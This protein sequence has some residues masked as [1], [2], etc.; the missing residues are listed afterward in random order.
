MTLQGSIT[1]QWQDIGFQ[2]DDPTTDFRGMGLLGL[3][4]LQYFAENHNSAARHVLSRSHH[5]VYGYSF[6]I[7]GIN[8]T[9]LAY[10]LLEDGSLKHHFYNVSVSNPRVDA[11]PGDPS[12]LS[13]PDLRHFHQLYC[14]LF[15][16]FDALWRNE[17]PKDIMEFSRIRDKFEHLLRQRLKSYDV[18]LKTDFVLENV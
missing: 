1:K 11:V 6:A 12:P 8:L 7:V 18:M 9:H 14:Y 3:A 5:P 2:G 15:F 17:K 16:E 10:T 4:N 13:R